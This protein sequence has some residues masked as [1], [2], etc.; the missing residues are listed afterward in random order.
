MNNK[1]IISVIVVLV[2]GFLG[3]YFYS[4]ELSVSDV[5]TEMQSVIKSDAAKDQSTQPEDISDSVN[6]VDMNALNAQISADV[7]SF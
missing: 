2:L 7:N 4:N 6:N 1:L 3:W 5:K